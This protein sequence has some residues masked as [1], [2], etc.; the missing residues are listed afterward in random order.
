MSMQSLPI[1]RVRAL[2]QAL[3]RIHSADH[4]KQFPETVFGALGDLLV[5]SFFSLDTLSLATGQ[6]IS[7]TSDNIPV[8][9][10]LKNRI[11]ELVPTNP[12]IPLVLRG[13]KGAIRI[14]DCI[15]QRQFEQTALYED[16]FVPLGIRYQTVVTLDIPGHIARITVNREIDFTD[17]EALL[18]NLAAP[19][20]ALAHRNLQRLESLRI[21]A[22]QVVPGPQDLERVGLTPRE[23]E[24]LHWVIKGKP[25][26]AIAA[27]LRISTR[28]VHQHIGRILRKLQSETRGSAGYEAMMK[29]KELETAPEPQ[30][31]DL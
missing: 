6:V 16:I 11:L 31:Q 25:D 14:T 4:I 20:I 3:E 5:G 30:L 18:L 22:A 1:H 27:I 7:A 2:M 13:A 12:A 19:Q 9:D 23:A 26:G 10:E 24:V 15:S 17:E 21:V 29:L 8:S 28:T